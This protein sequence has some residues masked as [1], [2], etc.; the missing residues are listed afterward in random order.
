M[1]RGGGFNKTQGETVG[2]AFEHVESL[3][4]A[5]I[6]K[7]IHS[8]VVAPVAHLARL[9]PALIVRRAICHTNLLAESTD[10]AEDVSLHLLHGTLGESLRHDTALA[11]V[12]LLVA[13]VVG[14]GSGMDKG[15][16]EL[17]LSDV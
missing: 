16:V 15:I 6:T 4:K 11:G 10:V 3:T 9:G 5:Q 12:D 13:G 14:V 1:A 8:K 7:N 2:W 17:G